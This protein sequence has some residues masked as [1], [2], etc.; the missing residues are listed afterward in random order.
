MGSA[1]YVLNVSFWFKP[2]KSWT[3]LLDSSVSFVG[4]NVVGF[5]WHV[6]NES[7]PAADSNLVRSRCQLISALEQMK[8]VSVES[9][10]TGGSD[11]ILYP[12]RDQEA[13]SPTLSPAGKALAPR[14]RYSVPR[15]RTRM[16][17][18]WA[19][20]LPIIMPSPYWR[21]A[22]EWLKSEVTCVFSWRKNANMYKFYGL[23]KGILSEYIYWVS[24]RGQYY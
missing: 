13:T 17:S 11:D 15:R 19:Y 8:S 4:I 10:P 2:M 24:R 5:G 21:L 3:I 20:R 16:W 7:S 6:I 22:E 12:A 23:F 18:F 14:C 1:H 9:P